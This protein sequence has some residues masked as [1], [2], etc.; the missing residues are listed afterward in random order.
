M[1]TGS[2]SPD[3]NPAG[4]MADRLLATEYCQKVVND[5]FNIV[6][7]DGQHQRT[8]VDIFCKTGECLWTDGPLSMNL[9][10]HRD[11]ADI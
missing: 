6:I 11:G 4:A 9:I 8:A 1:M 3:V 5:G 2:F 10:V 7:R